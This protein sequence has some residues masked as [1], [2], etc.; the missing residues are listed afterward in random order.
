MRA[1]TSR[2]GSAGPTTPADPIL[3]GRHRDG[4]DEIQL[5]TKRGGTGP[6]LTPTLLRVLRELFDD[7]DQAI[8]ADH[9]GD[10]AA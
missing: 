6:L 2:E 3:S 5:V 1:H 4:V 8:A 9:T 10:P 7:D